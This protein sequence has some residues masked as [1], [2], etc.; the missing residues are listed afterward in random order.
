ML[1]LAR[2][3]HMISTPLTSF[4]SA[5]STQVWIAMEESNDVPG[6]MEVNWLV[7]SADTCFVHQKPTL[8]LD[9]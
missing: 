6:V 8:V 5:N 2:M 1:G 3:H 9:A 7:F 4:N